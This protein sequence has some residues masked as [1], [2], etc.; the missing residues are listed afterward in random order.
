MSFNISARGLLI[1]GSKR[2]TFVLNKMNIRDSEDFETV[3]LMRKVPGSPTFGGVIKKAGG[4]PVSQ[5]GKANVKAANK[6]GE[7][8]GARL[9][10]DIV[11]K[12]SISGNGDGVIKVYCSNKGFLGGGSFGMVDFYLYSGSEVGKDF[13]RQLSKTLVKTDFNNYAVLNEI[14]MA[15]SGYSTK[16]E[17]YAG[18]VPDISIDLKR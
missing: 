14:A 13:L 10:V 15:L 2:G 3:K 4:T 5:L 18:A 8:I 16:L 12:L 1:S 9:I 11:T 7:M 6:L 17:S